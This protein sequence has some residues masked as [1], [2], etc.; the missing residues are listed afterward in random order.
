MLQVD[1]Y[2]ELLALNRAL[3]EVRYLAGDVD[4]ATRGS[5]FLSCLHERLINEIKENLRMSGRDGEVAHWENWENFANR[6][7]EPPLI[8][9]YLV[10]DWAQLPSPEVKREAVRN[11]L[12]PFKFS[13]EDVQLMVQELDRR[14]SEGKSE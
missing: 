9:E 6:K 3:M 4:D 10:Q 14:T 8:A 2:Q 5:S 7:I 13:T 11:Q 12:R 1:D